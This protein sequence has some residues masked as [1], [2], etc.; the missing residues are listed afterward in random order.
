MKRMKRWAE[1]VLFVGD[2]LRFLWF[3][4]RTRP[5]PCCSNAAG[6][7]DDCPVCGGEGRVLP[8]LAKQWRKGRGQG[9]ANTE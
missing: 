4:V 1:G 5:C 9:I 2:V 6:F 8:E 7:R 3:A